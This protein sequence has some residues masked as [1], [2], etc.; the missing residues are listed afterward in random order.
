LRKHGWIG[1]D[2]ELRAII[3]RIDMNGDS[4]ISENEFI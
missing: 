2:K 3:R 1:E 4:R